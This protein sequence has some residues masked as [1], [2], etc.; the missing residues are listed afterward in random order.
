MWLHAPMNLFGSIGDL[1]LHPLVVHFAVVLLPLSALA[2]VALVLVPRWRGPCGWPVM[3]GLL[4]GTGA[5]FVA[6]ESGEALAERIGTP[7]PH[8]D[9]GDLLPLVAALL[10][11]VGAVW[12]WLQRRSASA[13]SSGRSWPT[14]LTGVVAVLLAGVTVVLTILVGHS[15]AQ[16]VWEGEAGRVATKPTAA[17][18]TPALTLAEVHRHGTAADCWTVVNG[19]VYDVTSW[20]SQ[21]PGGP[22]VIEQM[23]GADA[24]AA[25]E[26]QHQGQGRPN[27]ELASFLLGRLA[28]SGS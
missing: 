19:S 27:D 28:T 17:A 2:L 5:A 1:P 13:P 10:L 24:T 8:A 12:F 18:T 20:I 16:A 9:L 23:C 6:K 15:G 21:H 22:Q 26:A 14:L 25:F 4:V 7:E 3:A 11:L